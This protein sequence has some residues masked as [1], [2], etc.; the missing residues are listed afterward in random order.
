MGLQICSHGNL[1]VQRDVF[2]D[3]LFLMMVALLGA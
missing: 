2:L 1:D 3:V